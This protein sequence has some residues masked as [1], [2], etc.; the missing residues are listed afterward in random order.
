MDIRPNW[1]SNYD[2]L[3]GAHA[4]LPKQ[5]KLN[6]QEHLLNLFPPLFIS[7]SISIG[8]IAI[9]CLNSICQLLF[10]LKIHKSSVTN[11]NNN[12]LNLFH[13]IP[14]KQSIYQLY[15]LFFLVYC[16]YF[17]MMWFSWYKDSFSAHPTFF[18]TISSH[19]VLA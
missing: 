8:I 17:S 5:Y 9:W 18:P 19:H 10:P 11:I 6:S 3:C 13:Y 4:V 7:Q 15:L 14:I 16:Y 1:I 12:H 2:L